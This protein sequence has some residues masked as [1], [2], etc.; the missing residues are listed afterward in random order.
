[1]AIKPLLVSDHSEMEMYGT[2]VCFTVIHV[3]GKG[4]AIPLQAW[5]G[6]YGSKRLRLSDFMTFGT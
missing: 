4:T 6:P 5:T 2:N 3:K 1:M